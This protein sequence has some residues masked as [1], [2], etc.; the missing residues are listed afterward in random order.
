M[1]SKLIDNIIFEINYKEG[2]E[3]KTVYR[4]DGNEMIE[5]IKNHL[6]SKGIKFE[7]VDMTFKPV[8]G[9]SEDES[10]YVDFIS[11]DKQP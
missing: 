10:L 5:M 7:Y 1:S 8:L 3:M 2:E 9:T 11:E 4:F 6:I